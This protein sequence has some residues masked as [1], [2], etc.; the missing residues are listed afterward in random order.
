MTAPE[1]IQLENI[2]D[3]DY[4]IFALLKQRYSPRIFKDKKITE[5][6]MHQL[7]EAVRWAPSSNNQQ[8]WRF[9][10][11]EKG[12]EAYKKIIDNLTDSNKIWAKNAPL[13]ML[14]AYY[15]EAQQ[16]FNIP[17]EFHIVT[18]IALGYYGG[19]LDDLPEKLQK[20]EISERQRMPQ[21]QFA[22][23]NSWGTDQNM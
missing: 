15:K 3:S 4:E 5:Q 8:P 14:T 9:L 12:S 22:F 18:A 21:N 1:Q 7:F 17:E 16:I 6:H 13:L 2:A 23:K 10:Y 11:A 19:E 20:K